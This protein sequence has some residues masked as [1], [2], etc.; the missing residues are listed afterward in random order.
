MEKET[1]LEELRLAR[2]AHIEWVERARMV[3]EGVE[4]AKEAVPVECTA[5]RFGRWWYGHGQTLKVL[6]NNN[7]DTMDKI[8][9][10]HRTI[11]ELYLEIFKIYFVAP[12]K[13]WYSVLTD[14]MPRKIAMRD[15]VLSRGYYRQIEAHSRELLEALQLVE[16]RIHAINKHEF[17]DLA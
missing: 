8:E 7:A 13:R 14:W 17:S 9:V 11:H 1:I 4:I 5:C 15:K 12:Q 3:I 6:R 2:S 10:S 16:R